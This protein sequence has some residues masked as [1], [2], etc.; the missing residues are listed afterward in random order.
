MR[1]SRKQATGWNSRPIQQQHNLRRR[2][3]AEIA[4]LKAERVDGSM[5]TP[6]QLVEIQR[7]LKA[8]FYARNPEAAA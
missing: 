5:F 3:N 6:A 7:D 8:Q 2:L 1:E 4:R